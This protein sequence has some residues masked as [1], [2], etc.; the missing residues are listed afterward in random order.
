MI[1]RG[2][3][4]PGPIYKRPGFIRGTIIFGLIGLF[5]YL[6]RS[7]ISRVL[8]ILWQPAVQIRYEFIQSLLKLIWNAIL[9]VGSFFLVLMLV[10]QFILPVQANEQRRKVFERLIAFLTRQHGPA[11]FIRGGKEI[12]KKSEL[13]SS[14]QGV[15]FV[16]L[17]SAIALEKQSPKK[18]TSIPQQDN[19]S[20][21]SKSIS[22][23]PASFMRRPQQRGKKATAVR[24][25]GP[26]ITFT[27]S[28]E[29]IRGVIDLRPQIRVRRGVNAYTREGIEIRTSITT[30]FTIGQLPEIMKVVYE[31][32]ENPENLRI[33]AL[34]EKA[35]RRDGEAIAGSQPYIK[36]LIDGLDLAD[37]LEIHRYVSDY[38]KTGGLVRYQT[39]LPK[40]EPS[41][42]FLFD[43]SRIFKA[44]YS[45]SLDIKEDEY[46]E[47]TDLPPY[48][49]TEVFRNLIAGEVYD[50]L[51]FPA[52]QNKFPLQD[53]KSNFAM[54]MRHQGVMAFQF[55]ERK[56]SIPFKAGQEWFEEHYIT[57]PVQELQNPKVLRARGIKVIHASFSDLTPVNPGVRDQLLDNWSAYWENEA[58]YARVEHE[59][60]RT[61]IVNKAR[62]QAQINLKDQLLSLLESS[63]LADDA[64]AL[65]M[66]QALESV[67]A[68]PKTRQ[69]LPADTISMLKSIW[70]WLWGGGGQF[71]QID[72][73]AREGVSSGGSIGII[74]PDDD[75]F[76]TVRLDDLTPQEHPQTGKDIITPDEENDLEITD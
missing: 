26:G 64:L 62:I 28:G 32:D 47:W 43:P 13:L 10:S 55:L 18:P 12:A 19:T 40:E 75:V 14:L 30:I 2:I 24:I 29:A 67:A 56:D 54:K 1:E 57:Y 61:R 15:A 60:I 52:D 20:A 63:T 46:K 70:E 74:E 45:S 33:V 31:G 37:K 38:R 25:A 73:G 50:Y 66:L 5:V 51:Y 34:A 49:A 11:V 6:F 36:E 17:T 76:D 48:I 65:R 21:R 72:P 35:V 68:D 9:F 27:E 16:D 4:S 22:F 58:E 44:I 59:L 39:S 3:F 71:P 23:S 53:L 42:P 8:Q 7:E 41:S 69:F